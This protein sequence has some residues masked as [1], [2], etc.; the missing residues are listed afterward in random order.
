MRFLTETSVFKF[1]WRNVDGVVP[2]MDT[3]KL[4]WTHYVYYTTKFA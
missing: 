2:R 3:L 1:R 4:G